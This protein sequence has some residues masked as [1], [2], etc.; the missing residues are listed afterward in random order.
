MI[1]YLV[2]EQHSRPMRYF[3]QAQGSALASR[4]KVVTYESLLDGD[5][6][7]PQR[8]GSYIFTNL[9]RV[10]MMSPQLRTRVHD[11]HRHLV[12]T[13][14][15]ARVHNDPARSLLRFDL[16]RALHKAGINSFNACRACD[17]T[18]RLRLPAFIRHETQTAFGPPILANDPYE[19]SA[20]LLGIRWLRNDFDS[21]ISVEFCDT[22]DASRVYR[23]YGAFVVG[24]RI[25]PRHVFFSRHWHVKATDI[26]DPML[27]GEE[28]QFLRDSSQTETLL[29]CAR[30]AGISY[31]R[32]DYAMFN[33]RPQ[34]WEIN[35][36]AALVFAPGGDRPERAQVHTNFVQMF[37][38]AMT[39]LDG[40]G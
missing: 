18:A 29:Q 30:L 4:I 32:I 23:K 7:L 15:E 38:E 2:T 5:E 8:G 9:G 24:D 17:A 37:S 27:V 22:A 11:M 13:H 20:H 3:L 14:G 28:L 25:V 19:Y 21:F 34:V 39:A 1:H 33:G 26:D 16:L 40:E 35:T 31:G 6:Q 10:R 36:N 12:E